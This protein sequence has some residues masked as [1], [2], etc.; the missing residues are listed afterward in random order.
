MKLEYAY[1][2]TALF[3]NLHTYLYLK[4]YSININR[5]RAQ[6]KFVLYIINV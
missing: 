5:V 1:F 4:L 3:T 2:Q 6:L